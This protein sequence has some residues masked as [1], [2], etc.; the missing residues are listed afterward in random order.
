[1]SM[2][3]FQETG[4]SSF[5]D[6]GYGIAG[7]R[8]GQVAVKPPER[9]FDGALPTALGNHEW[10]R[11]TRMEETGFSANFSMHGSAGPLSLAAAAPYSV[12]HF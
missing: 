8:I 7:S 3:R 5:V 4:Q 6:Y 9:W 12:S 1:M 11:K 2:L 10:T